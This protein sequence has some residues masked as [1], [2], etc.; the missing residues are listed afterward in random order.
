MEGQGQ[1]CKVQEME[2]LPVIGDL[3]AFQLSFQ[4]L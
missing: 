3:D 1:L 4:A 2:A